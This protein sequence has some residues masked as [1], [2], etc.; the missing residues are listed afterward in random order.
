MSIRGVCLVAV[1]VVALAMLGVGSY[2]VYPPAGLIVPGLALWLDLQI[3]S[4]KA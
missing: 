1:G 4:M 3:G 2:C